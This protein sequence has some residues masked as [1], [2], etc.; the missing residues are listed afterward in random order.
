MFKGNKTVYRDPNVFIPGTWGG[1]KIL[2]GL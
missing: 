1:L 2:E